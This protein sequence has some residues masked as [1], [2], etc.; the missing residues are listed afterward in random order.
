MNWHDFNK[1]EQDII[2]QKVSGFIEKFE[3]RA[4]LKWCETGKLLSNGLCPTPL[5]SAK[6]ELFFIWL[7]FKKW[8]LPF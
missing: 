3:K 2:G 5:T 7:K 6:F 4:L 8:I 1:L